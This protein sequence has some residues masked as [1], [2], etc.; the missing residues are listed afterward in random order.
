MDNKHAARNRCSAS[1]ERTAWAGASGKRPTPNAQRPT[2]NAERKIKVE[3]V[4]PNALAWGLG[5]R[6]GDNAI[7]LIL[8]PT[9]SKSLTREWNRIE[10]LNCETAASEASNQRFAVRERPTPKVFASEASSESE[11]DLS[12]ICC[13]AQ[14]TRTSRLR[15]GRHACPSS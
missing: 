15:R 6:V 14:A 2:L 3:R 5:H 12:Q 9:Q 8:G 1:L 10:A 13:E 4:V 7:H 11:C